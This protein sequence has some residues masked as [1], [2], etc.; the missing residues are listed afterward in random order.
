[1]KL[2]RGRAACLGHCC[3]QVIWREEK[4]IFADFRTGML[5]SRAAKAGRLN[6]TD[7]MKERPRRPGTA[8][9]SREG[10]G[11]SSRGEVDRKSC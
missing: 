5:D 2:G 6:F 1:M 8:A 9:G 3:F 7:L 11:D 10:A 4:I